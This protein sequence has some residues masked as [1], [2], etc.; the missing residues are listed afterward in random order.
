MKLLDITLIRFPQYFRLLRDSHRKQH[1]CHFQLFL[2]ITASCNLTEYRVEGISLQME[3]MVS[4]WGG[5]GG[6]GGI[7][8][9]PSRGKQWKCVPAICKATTLKGG[10]GPISHR[11]KGLDHARDYIACKWF[12]WCY[13]LGVAP[14]SW[15]HHIANAMDFTLCSLL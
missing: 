11:R 15:I 1:E 9:S 6:G 7:S 13:S 14:N 2:A 3:T 12:W 5:G 8:F 4:L 10:E